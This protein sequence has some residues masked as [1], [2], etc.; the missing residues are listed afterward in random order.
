[1][2]EFLKQVCAPHFWPIVITIAVMLLF[3][4][5]GVGLKPL[6]NAII[7][8]FGKADTEVT[9]NLGAK[10][11]EPMALPPAQCEKCRL[12]EQCQK[13]EAEALRSH[14]NERGIET[15]NKRVDDIWKHIETAER[16][17]A[18]KFD[19]LQTQIGNWKT[20]IVNNQNRI[21]DLLKGK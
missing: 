15:V 2:E 3:F 16:E 7:K 12:W 11:G 10:E 20:E 8:W 21:I 14:I 13:H 6:I 1:M 5:A 18:A 19:H 9:V 4:G 17:T